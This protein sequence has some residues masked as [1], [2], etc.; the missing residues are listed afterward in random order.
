MDSKMVLDSFRVPINIQLLAERWSN[1]VLGARKKSMKYVIFGVTGFLG[2]RLAE[3]LLKKGLH[4]VGVAR[5]E[6]KLV[7]LKEQF[8]KLEIITGDIADRWIVKKAMKGAYGVFLLSG[9]KHVGLAEQDVFQ[10]VHTNVTGVVNVLEESME[11]LPEF[12]V[13][14][15]TDKAAQISG[16]YGSTKKIGEKLFEEAE[17][18]NPKTKYR[19]V[20]YGN[21]FGST[22]SFI[23]KWIPKMKNEEEIILTDPDATRFFWTREDAINLIFQCLS[24]AKDSKPFIPAMKAVSMGTVLDACMDVYGKTP[25]RIIGLQPGENKHETMDGITFSN[26]V[27]QFTKEEFKEKFL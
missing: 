12:V 8:P 11:T 23:T 6:G 16:V 20:R 27:P 2:E 24:E 9:Y 26:Q 22:G 4:V 3:F 17:G 15:S 18:M 21:V 25:A 14:T 1:Q 7:A 13:F 5:N 10:C 19:V